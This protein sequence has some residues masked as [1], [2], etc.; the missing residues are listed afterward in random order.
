MKNILV[1]CDFSS[2]AI[3]AYRLALDIVAM[4]GGKVHVLNVIELPYMPNTAFTPVRALGLPY[5][6]EMSAKAKGNF[7]KIRG[8]Y[9]PDC[10]RNAF[11]VASG[12]PSSVILAFAKKNNI[13]LIIM[14]SHGAN[15]MR[16]FFV[17]STTE[18]IVRTSSVPVIVVKTLYKGSLNNIVVPFSAEMES[19]DG[20]IQNIKSLQS[21][22]KAHL[23]IVWVNTPA[24]FSPDDVTMKRI[25]A[26]I[27][28][29]KIKNYTICIYNH[30]YEE[31]GILKYADSIDADM[32]AMGTHGRRGLSHMIHG[33]KTEQVARH[34]TSLIW[35]SVMN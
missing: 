25:T 14:G 34:G 21:F 7:E 4:S 8:K 9:G 17:G 19:Q 29:Y 26:M 32:I 15:A 22:F 13:D 1:P 20:L 11:R 31:S 35:T 30:L 27:K 6:K 10:V 28:K 2:A 23:H 3:N 16:D 18:K 5:I 33:S 24:N 12:S